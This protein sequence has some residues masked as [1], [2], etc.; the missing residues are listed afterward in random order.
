MSAKV[1]HAFS[2]RGASEMEKMITSLEAMR[3]HA[4]LKDRLLYKYLSCALVRARKIN[5]KLVEPSLLLSGEV[6]S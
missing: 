3:K 2:I 6:K 5:A 4:E 1:R